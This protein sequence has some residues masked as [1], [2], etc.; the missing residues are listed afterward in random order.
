MAVPNVPF[1]LS[2]ANTEFA[3]NGWASN[4]MSNAGLAI[5]GMASSL[6][7]KSAQFNF[8]L[9]IGSYYNG[10]RTQV[11]ANDYNGSVSPDSFDGRVISR[12]FSSDY[13]PNEIYL[14]LS[15][16]AKAYTL[17]IDGA[18]SVG[19]TSN[20]GGVTIPWVGIYAWLAAR[21]NSGIACN[22]K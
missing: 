13:S 16:A 22:L 14:R 6:A 3:G 7:G 18:G 19:F 5:P 4:I 1:W 10:Y 9:N 8:T 20:G 17:T 11:G 12:L 15:G 21:V 2:Q